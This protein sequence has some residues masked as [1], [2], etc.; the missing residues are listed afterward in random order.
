MTGNVFCD[1]ALNKKLVSFASADSTQPTGAGEKSN[2]VILD[3]EE[4]ELS[5]EIAISEDH[6]RICFCVPSD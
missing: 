1:G 3:L 4:D 2:Q 5:G 6:K